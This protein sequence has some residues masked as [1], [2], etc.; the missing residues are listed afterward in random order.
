MKLGI[1]AFTATAAAFREVVTASMP[2]GEVST[3]VSKRVPRSLTFDCKT[4]RA[5]HVAGNVWQHSG[6]AGG[7]EVESRGR[8]ATLAPIDDAPPQPERNVGIGDL[9]T[10]Y[11]RLLGPATPLEL[12]KYLGSTTA[13][14]KKVWPDDLVE[15]TVDGRRAWLPHQS[16]GDLE[17]AERP[18]GVRLLP[19]MDPLLQS[20]DRD[21]LVPSRDQ[22]KQVW[23]VLGNPGALLLDG[24]IAGVWRAKMAGRRRVDLTVTP[25]VTLSAAQRAR[26]DDEAAQVA[27]GR[28]AAEATVTLED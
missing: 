4:C 12:G 15:L 11:L 6:L 17:A 16:V 24:E 20:R 26:L 9:I 5:R 10:T 25:F 14:I 23:R 1:A 3:E 21:L 27:R 13:E 8:D 19:P 18:S 7:I 22:Q 28:G 2:R